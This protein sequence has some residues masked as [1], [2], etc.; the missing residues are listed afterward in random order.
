METKQLMDTTKI[1]EKYFVNY[2]IN[3]GDLTKIS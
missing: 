3:Q 1:T 2:F